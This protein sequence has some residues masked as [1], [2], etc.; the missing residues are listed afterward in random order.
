MSESTSRPPTAVG[1][2]SRFIQRALLTTARPP[3]L[4]AWRDVYLAVAGIAARALTRGEDSASVYL[5]GSVGS[6]EF[7]P[8]L[9]DIDLVIVLEPGAVEAARR[10]H[11]RWERLRRRAPLVTHLLDR[12]RAQTEDELRI[13]AGR[14][15][16]TFGLGDGLS[17]QPSQDVA[18]TA[19]LDRDRVL[20]RPGLVG[21]TEGWHLI[22]GADRRPADPPRDD[23]QVR[24]AVWLELVYLWKRAFGTIVDATPPHTAALC[25]K[26]VSD[27]TRALLWLDRR[28]LVRT[29]G[30]AL[31]RA[32]ELLPSHADRVARVTGLAHEL[33]LMPEPPVADA[34]SLLA[35]LTTLIAAELERQLASATRSTVEL[36][37]VVPCD[38]HPLCDWPALVRPRAPEEVFALGGGL[39]DANAAG[40]AIA[41]RREGAF[42]ALRSGDVLAFP[43]S[44]RDHAALRAVACPVTDPVSAA[45]VAQ[46]TQAAFPN[47]EGW[48]ALHWARRA[49]A[50]HRQALVDGRAATTRDL[51]AAA[52]AATF[53][54]T[55]AEGVPVLPVTLDAT[56]ALL[57]R[58]GVL[59]DALADN[60]LDGLVSER[61]GGGPATD[62]VAL[63]A[64]VTGL[65][66][67]A[68]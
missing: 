55:L 21:A 61:A 52:R 14:S 17:D 32:A 44:T 13:L 38:V 9:S 57:R 19:R 42:T 15:S 58:R 29:R 49:V 7:V 31:E 11:Q 6:Q 41:A 54:A 2:S 36:D 24:I 50:E 20:E 67:F 27:A 59:S 30:E 45:V 62:L 35:A 5:R 64:V 26:L 10:V 22:R 65:E 40:A 18:G 60:A 1:R 37:G 56:V 25:V 39:G 8:A 28:E 53:R 4:R 46:T 48:S 43:S 16:Y 12:P 23:Q 34:L 66:P 63:R 68:G 33:R 3:F 51:L 47:V